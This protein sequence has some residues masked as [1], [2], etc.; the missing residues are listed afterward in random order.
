MPEIDQ[1]APTAD[2]GRRRLGV[3]T[4]NSME[5]TATAEARYYGSLA[6]QS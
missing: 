2:G 6:G 3:D 1:K 4:G 5:I